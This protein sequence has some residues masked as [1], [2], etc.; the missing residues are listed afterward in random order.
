MPASVR[1]HIVHQLNRSSLNYEI[2]WVTDGE[3]EKQ[4]INK[5]QQWFWHLSCTYSSSATFALTANLIYITKLIINS[6]AVRWFLNLF[7]SGFTSYKY[8]M[9]AQQL[10]K[11]F[12]YSIKYLCDYRWNDIYRSQHALSSALKPSTKSR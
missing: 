11:L 8:N 1:N 6:L 7:V 2:Y 10:G 4:L 9:I 3:V 12:V 5:N